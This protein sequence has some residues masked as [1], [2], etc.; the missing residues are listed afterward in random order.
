[1]VEL[2]TLPNTQT[3]AHTHT[4]SHRFLA[5]L[6]V[7]KNF[8][9]GG[10]HPFMLPPWIPNSASRTN[11]DSFLHGMIMTSTQSLPGLMFSGKSHPVT[12]LRL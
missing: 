5:L 1:M 7:Q 11:S 6:K 9:L 2:D 3:H 4:A 10:S 12:E 8:G